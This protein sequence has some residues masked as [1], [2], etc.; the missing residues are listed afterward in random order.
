[1]TMQNVIEPAEE[2]IRQRAYEIWER[3]GRPQGREADHWSQARWELMGEAATATADP[4][5]AA[6]ATPAAAPAPKGGKATSNRRA[7][8]AAVEGNGAA[9]AKA[10]RAKTRKAAATPADPETGTSKAGKARTTAAKAAP[11]KAG[12]KSKKAEG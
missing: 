12:A 7:K 5:P 8:T 4:Q 10:T 2:A 6:P 1:M 11:K 9:S 3:E